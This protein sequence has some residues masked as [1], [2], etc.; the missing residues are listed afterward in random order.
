MML[1]IA[2][3][4]SAVEVDDARAALHRAR[5]VDGRASAGWAG[6]AVKVNKQAREDNEIVEALR[7]LIVERLQ[8]NLLFQLAARPKRILGPVFSRYEVSDAYGAHTDEPVMDGARSDVSFTL[9]LSSP[10]S[11][12]GGELILMTAAGD[13]VIKL[14]PG[15][16]FVYPATTLHR[17]APV[18]GGARLVAAGWVRSHVR[19]AAQREL[20]FDLD[21]ARREM[22]ERDGQSAAFNLVSKSYANLMRMWCED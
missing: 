5:F 7:D 22:F 20:L 6:Q 16:L 21:Q 18:T 4:L 8:S 13:D 10:E 11:Y 1:S 3:V 12:T 15:S 2:D 9:F 17:V 19:C 14:A